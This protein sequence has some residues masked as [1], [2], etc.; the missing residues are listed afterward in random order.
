MLLTQKTD[1]QKELESSLK[2]F[3]S[4]C[5]SEPTPTFQATLEKFCSELIARAEALSKNYMVTENEMV[6]MGCAATLL[7]AGI[8]LSPKDAVKSANS[9]A[10]VFF[11]DLPDLQRFQPQTIECLDA[12][13]ST[14]Q[15]DTITFREIFYDAVISMDAQK[16]FEQQIILKNSLHRQNSEIARSSTA[17][18]DQ[19]IENLKS[20]EFRTFAGQVMFTKRLEKNLAQTR[21]LKSLFA[22]NGLLEDHEKKLLTLYRSVSRNMIDMIAITDRKAGLLLSANAISLSLVISF[23]SKG[24]DHQPRLWTSAIVICGTCALTVLFA[25]LAAR[26]LNRENTKLTLKELLNHDKSVLHYGNAARLS[27]EDFS[28]GFKRI[29][30]DNDLLE[31]GLIEEL[32]FYSKRIISKLKMVRIAYITMFSGMCLSFLVLIFAKYL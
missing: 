31:E 8:A 23:L 5:F 3:L 32:H 25:S 16:E 19:E 12:L 13:T 11:K 20:V 1:Q 18:I 28:I 24:I 30:N 2:R 15:S 14:P 9:L 6:A 29:M 17:W 26:P 21:E 4:T 27:R 22:G 7:T 10:G